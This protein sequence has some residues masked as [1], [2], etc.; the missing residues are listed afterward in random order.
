MH[1]PHADQRWRDGSIG[2]IAPGGPR[3]TS[4][5][6][7]YRWGKHSTPPARWPRSSSRGRTSSRSLPS[8]TGPSSAEDAPGAAIST[9]HLRRRRRCERSTP[10]LE[11]LYPWPGGS[12]TSS[13]SAGSVWPE[14]TG[15]KKSPSCVRRCRRFS[16]GAD[17][18][19]QRCGGAIAGQP[20][21]MRSVSGS[22]AGP[23]WQLVLEETPAPCGTEALR[24][25][26]G[27]PAYLLGT[28][29]LPD[30][31]PDVMGIGDDREAIICA[32]EQGEA[33]GSTP[34]ALAWLEEHS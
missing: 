5:I 11:G 14:R 10:R 20:H 13:A 1:D 26:P 22:T 12:S 16:G 25:N 3:G 28:S 34:G 33:W 2:D 27:V 29:P 19:G 8:A 7:L 23:S 32:A 4:Q 18:S 21:R 31:L 9:V 24:A 17:R 15:L 30:M 6:H